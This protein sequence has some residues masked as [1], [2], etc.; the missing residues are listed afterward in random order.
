MLHYR[1]T[2]FLSAF[3]LFSVQLVLG[4]YLLPWFGGTPAMWTTCMLFFQT[5][6]LAGYVYAHAL[7]TWSDTPRAQITVHSVVLVLSLLIQI[8]LWR[9]WHSPIMPDASW[10]PH[11]SDYP[12]WTVITL[13]TVSV[14]APYFVL[15]S[16]GPLLQA[17]FARTH[18]RETP[19]RLYAL[20]NLGSFLA[21]LAYPFLVEPQLT[22]KTQARLWSWGFLG[23]AM[24]CGYCAW[25]F[26]K[27]K[28]PTGA[29]PSHGA[30]GGL[31]MGD[32]GG[33]HAAQRRSLRAV[34]QPAG[35]RLD[36]VSGHHQPDLS[37]HR[38]HSPALGSAAQ[39]V[40]TVL[41]HLL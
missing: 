16:T 24:G 11:G 23:Y 20:S 19:Y 25:R 21:L 3:L 32:R 37:G 6:L 31:E 36:H 7:T 34:A 27:N 10:K 15:S 1:F 12:I 41:R 5:L 8:V 40:S 30:N 17:W 33:G 26:V 39:P 4:K 9:T 2:V 13:L 28:T 38:C 22:L 29:S 14:G 35:V 18:P